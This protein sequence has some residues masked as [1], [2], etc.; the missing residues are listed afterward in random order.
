MYGRIMAVVNLVAPDAAIDLCQMLKNDFKYQVAKR[1]QINIE[2]KIKVIRFIAELVKFG[3]YAK[4]EALMCLKIL[5]YN[6]QH[7]QIEM[8][9][10][11]LEVCG[12]YLYNCKES[13]LRTLAALEKMMRLKTAHALDARHVAQVE[14]CYFLVKPPDD[15]G[16]QVKQRPPIHTYIRHLI[17]E[18]LNKTNVD[19]MIKLMRKFDYS[20]VALT[21]YIVKCLTK[22]YNLRYHLI[23]YLADLL[24]GLSSYREQVVAR[25][26][27]NV[28]EDV[29]AGLEIHSPKL[30][31]RRVAMVTYLGE[32]FNYRL[33]SAT[34]MINTLYLII[35]FG[36]SM[37]YEY[38]SEVDPPGSMFRLKLACTLLSTCGLY[39]TK[40]SHR[41]M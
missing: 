34:H 26:V 27:D 12:Q 2:S 23:K 21:D 22:A 19:M 1:D 4:L 38:P 7:H 30:A 35:S 36:V 41:K 15:I 31:Q 10:A 11:F 37:N 3:L 6:F 14:N 39:F 29:R 40:Q 13:R 25:V 32:M 8:T 18:E 5:L 9:C 24:S 28:F 16:V 17:F 33:V 20:D